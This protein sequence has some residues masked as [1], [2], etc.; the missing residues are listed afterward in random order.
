MGRKRKEFAPGTLPPA[1][2]AR[3]LAG[4]A[5]KQEGG[6]ADVSG[7]NPIPPIRT[8]VLH[9][10]VRAIQDTILPPP[11]MNTAS[12]LVRSTRRQSGFSLIEMIGVLAIIAILAVV[13]VPKV[14]T[15]IEG[16]RITAA[17]SSINAVRSAV[18]DFAGKY[19]TI[20]ATT[21][22]SRLDDLFL[23][24]GYM[25]S[26]FAVKIGTPPANPPIASATWTYANGVWTAAGG[27][28]QASQSRI[29]RLLSNVTAPSTANGANYRLNGVT[30]LPAGSLVASA[31][32][33]NVTGSQA[34]QLSLKID[35]DP[36]SA[37]N[38]TTADA[39]GKVVY[40]TPTAAGLTTAYVYLA[41]Q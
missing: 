31:V 18:T 27:A 35:G 5:L 28:N 26:R 32:L 2:T 14:F 21:A 30:D 23:A 40:N 13:I 7:G 39:A 36:Y 15:T 11:I 33:V 20:P 6:W 22:N 24:A 29:I 10:P 9:E 4:F 12:G 37:A 25:D 16:S 38:A 3:A 19:G 17:V 8:C 1:P 41:H 34:Q